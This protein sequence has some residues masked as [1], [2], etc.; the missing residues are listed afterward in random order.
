[1]LNVLVNDR[2]VLSRTVG[3][4]SWADLRIPLGSEPAQPGKITL[5]LV[6]PENQRWMEGLFFDYIDFFDN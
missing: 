2:Q 4:D 6:V 3:V 1:V 5:E